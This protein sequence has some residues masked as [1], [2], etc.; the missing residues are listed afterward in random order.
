MNL[1]EELAFT[2]QLNLVAA[3]ACYSVTKEKNMKRP[4]KNG[5]RIHMTVKA[6]RKQ[7]LKDILS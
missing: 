3:V 5:K 6:N 7:N 4:M 2:F 1:L